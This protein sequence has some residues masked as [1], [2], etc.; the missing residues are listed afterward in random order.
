VMKFIA[1]ALEVQ[2]QLDILSCL[3]MTPSNPAAFAKI[4]AELAPYAITSTE[5][6]DKVVFNDPD[7]WAQNG[8]DAVNAFLE[9]IS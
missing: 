5:N 1:Q 2:S 6:I 7:W 9:A 4:P 8:G 3:G